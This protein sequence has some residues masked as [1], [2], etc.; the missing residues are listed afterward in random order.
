MK[1]LLVRG[2]LALVGLVAI[3]VV[4]L[5]FSLNSII[6]KVVESQGTS[7]TGVATTLQS[8]SLN[9]F[10]GALSLSEFDLANPEGFSN[11]TIFK[12]GK[13]DVK[14]QIGSLMGG[15]EIVIDKLHL[16]GAEV[17][18]A[19]EG[20]KLN[21]QELL[22]Q[23]NKNV[24]GEA[25]GGEPKQDD[26]PAEEGQSKGI[27]I[28]DM[29]IT[30]TTV[31]GEISLLPGTPP[32]A[33]DFKIANIEETDFREADTGAVI[34]YVMQTIMINATTGLTENVEGLGEIVGDLGKLG[35]EAIGNASEDANKAIEDAGKALEEGLGG[36]LGGGKKDKKE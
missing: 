1:K 27:L 20:G 34:G 2:G 5:Y 25:E 4:V 14:I 10:G 11:A 21:I 31:R 29:K 30:N 32:I 23:I 18:V 16:D 19:L 12:L 28:K 13:A 24:G 17:V 7:A 33:L 15:D 35:T 8:V 26:A 9:P 6:K 22:N 36:L 3:G